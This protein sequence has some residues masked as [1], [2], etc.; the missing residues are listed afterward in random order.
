MADEGSCLWYIRGLDFFPQLPPEE[1]QFLASRSEMLDW[2]KGTEHD[3]SGGAKDTVY[4]LK[5]GRVAMVK[6][7]SVRP[8]ILDILGP[9]DIIGLA[10]ATTGGA[11]PETV[12][13]L[14]DALICQIRGDVLRE[15]LQRHGGVALQLFQR[16]G[17]RRYR[18]ECRLLDMVYQTVPV[19]VA[20]MLLELDERYG[21]NRDG[22]RVLAMALRVGQLAALVGAN[23]EATNR[24]LLSFA[25]RGWLMWQGRHMVLSDLPGLRA[26]AYEEPL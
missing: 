25:D 2:S 19:R 14:E 12:Q 18:I 10:T 4:L 20:R 24:A 11:L 8:V 15:I 5:R 22:R 1:E 13:A 7:G 9:G 17:L 21:E 3:V 26:F 16:V 6:S 23:R